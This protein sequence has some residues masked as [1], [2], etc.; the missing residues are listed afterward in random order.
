MNNA[1]KLLKSSIF[2]VKKQSG[3]AAFDNPRP[4]VGLAQILKGNTGKPDRA[5]QAFA[6][7]SGFATRTKGIRPW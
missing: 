5:E 2:K 1:L 4:P 7:N 3:M 6:T